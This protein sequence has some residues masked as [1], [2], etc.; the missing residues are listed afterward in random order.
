MLKSDHRQEFGRGELTFKRT[1]YFRSAAAAG[2]F[3]ILGFLAA[4]AVSGR[5]ERAGAS[6]QIRMLPSSG[7]TPSSLT[8]LRG[9]LVTWVND[10]KL[11]HTVTSSEGVFAS[12]AIHSEES[13]FFRFEV[14]GTYTYFSGFEPHMMGKIVVH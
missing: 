9:T 5:V 7:F 13:F 2:G 11:P 14:P 6:V 12:Q 1:A 8:V 10:D 4:V 3:M